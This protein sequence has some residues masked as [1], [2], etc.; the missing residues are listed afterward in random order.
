MSDWL[1]GAV[2]MQALDDVV[3]ALRAPR[4]GQAAHIGDEA[5]ELARRHFAV[6]RR[7]FGQITNYAF[8]R[9]RVLDH[10]MPADFRAA[11]GRREKA[12]NHFH[13]GGFSGAVGAEEP[14]YAPRFQFEGDAVHGGQLP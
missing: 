7:T 8:C 6:A 4:A 10:V 1:A 14:E 12:R 2:Q 3:Q 5:E 13:R 9:E 11:R